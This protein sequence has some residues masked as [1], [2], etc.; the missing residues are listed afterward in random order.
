MLPDADPD[1]FRSILDRLSSPADRDR[2][3]AVI[4]PAIQARRSATSRWRSQAR[5]APALL[6]FA[7]PELVWPMLMH[8]DDPSLSTE[9]IHI[10]ADY[11]V[12]PKVLIERL[13][14]ETD[15]SVRRA[16]I[17]VLGGFAP[18]RVPPPLRA[19]LKVLLLSWYS[20]DPIPASMAQSTG[21]CGRGGKP[22]AI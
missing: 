21:S 17:L 4:L 3:L 15:R 20:S 19:D 12:D 13:K 5:L 22:A 6:E 2:A 8:R 16:L 9:L 10:L 1:Q 18:D 11:E 14:V 7:R